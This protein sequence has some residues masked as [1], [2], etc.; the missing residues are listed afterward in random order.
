[1]VWHWTVTVSHTKV[2]LPPPLPSRGLPLLFPCFTLHRP[3]N[4]NRKN[5]SRRPLRENSKSKKNCQDGEFGLDLFSGMAVCVTVFLLTGGMNIPAHAPTSSPSTTESMSSSLAW[6]PLLGPGV[7]RW[8]GQPR[9]IPRRTCRTR[10]S[11][12]GHG[13]VVATWT[14]SASICFLFF[15]FVVPLLFM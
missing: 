6:F 5:N 12:G 10:A 15:D 13:G 9:R 11:W 2:P 4:P 8:T 14:R 1:M 7:A 3:P